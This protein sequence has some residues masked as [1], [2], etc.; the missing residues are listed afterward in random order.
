MSLA[1]WKDTIAVGLVSGDII[2]LDAVTGGQ[3]AIL[4][5]HTGWMRS[6]AFSSDGTSL[7]SGSDDKTLK[8]WDMQT[9]GVVRTFQG[10]T[11]P[12]YSVSISSDC[13]TIASGSNDG[14]V[15]LWNFQTGECYCVLELQEAVDSVQFSP[16][17]PQHL[18]S[19]SDHVVQQW[20][21]NGHQIK[22]TY[23]GSDATFSSDGAQIVYGGNIV[24]VRDS[25][26][27]A[28]TAKCL[29]PATQFVLLLHLPQW[30][31]HSCC[32]CTF[33]LCMGY[34]QPRPPPH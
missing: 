26:S 18:I 8:L 19:V 20:D 24:T 9:G 4:S 15:H 11:G 28:I 10:H 25:G 2:I 22:S 1:C 27:G 30:Q 14:T 33:C 17:D 21:T 29:G 5:G 6:L 23:E 31:T 3:L 12:V 16:T 32:C 13:T 34:H 7:V